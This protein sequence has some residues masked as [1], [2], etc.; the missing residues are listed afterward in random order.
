MVGAICGFKA[1]F[2]CHDLNPVNEQTVFG[3][4][5]VGLWDFCYSF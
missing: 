1:Q 4:S 2:H 5:S 3:F